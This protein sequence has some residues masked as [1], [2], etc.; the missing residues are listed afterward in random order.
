MT[1][2]SAVR[3]AALVVANPQALQYG[4]TPRHQF[5]TA[6]GTI[7]SQG[8]NWILVD[9]AGHVQPIHCEICHSDAAF[10]VIDRCGQTH[11]NNASD[12]LGAMVGA[13]LRDGDVLRV[14]P[15]EITVH[16]QDEH[17]GPSNAS[18]HLAQYEVSELLNQRHEVDDGL[19]AERYSFERVQD[20]LDADAAF[21]AM[22]TTRDPQAEL[23][24]LLALDAAERAATPAP[25]A[26]HGT[27]PG[28]W[29]GA[30]TPTHPDLADTR[31]A[32]VAGSLNTSTGVST[33]SNAPDHYISAQNWPDGAR[34]GADPAQAA[35]PFL[36]GLG[37]PL[38][39]I[40]PLDPQ[41]SHN[42]L[43]EAGQALGAAIRG[44][45]TLYASPAATPRRAAVLARTLQ[46]IEDNPLRLGQSYA[47]T[48]RA[49]FSSQ[50]S[51][52]HLA[53]VAAIDESMAQLRAHH[54]AVGLAIDAALAALLEAF[55]PE[56]LLQR[57][58]RYQAEQVQP[59]GS[60]DWAWRMYTHYYEELISARQR[61][62][63]K[64]FWEI[65]EQAYDRA[66]RA[67]PQ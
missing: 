56:V 55:S 62:V 29:N 37:V 9:K 15:Y 22:A 63:E 48:V 13:R 21:D 33:M 66:L 18:R 41:A 24:P 10:C 58:R 54:E 7:G 47:D 43:L 20:E 26:L 67:R 50:R 36:Q 4:S 57:F 35:G 25:P 45:A 16:L 8:A 30:S 39:P 11:V 64:L 51:V 34:A 49:M 59:D 38:D 2:V 40:D 32:A 65:F 5:D 27:D 46:P 53:P 19:P 23:D 28:R 60:H 1:P 42:L 17:L 61:G 6:G 44:I 3:T 14:G 31:F 52:V 12:P